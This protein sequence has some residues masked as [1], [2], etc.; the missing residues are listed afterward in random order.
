MRSGFIIDAHRLYGPVQKIDLDLLNSP[1]IHNDPGIYNH[2]YVM[3]IY[4]NTVYQNRE[5]LPS[6][7]RPSKLREEE[8]GLWL[9]RLILHER[10]RDL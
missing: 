8:S 5:D 4:M 7:R 9:R 2:C 10:S 1:E 3:H 6:E